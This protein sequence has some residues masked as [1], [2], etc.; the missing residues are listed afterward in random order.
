MSS[1][2]WFSAMALIAGAGVASGQTPIRSKA[3]S[4]SA[5]KTPTYDAVVEGMSC[6]QK[7]S[8]EMWCEYK[9]GSAIHFIITR[10]GQAD[11]SVMFLKV[12][13]DGSY[14]AS[15]APLNGCVRVTS[16]A[17]TAAGANP[18]DIAFVSPHDGKVYRY[19][20]AC[21]KQ[22]VPSPSKKP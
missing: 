19:W 14:G 10:V 6:K 20:N 3:A 9:I 22:P 16:R 13:E 21:L 15:I 2:A 8:G 4:D 12:A 18:N 1:R 7:S 17:D 11:V 5:S